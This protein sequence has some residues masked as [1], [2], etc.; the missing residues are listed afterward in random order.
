MLSILLKP[1]VW[2]IL[3]PI[4]IFSFVFMITLGYFLQKRAN[5]DRLLVE[6]RKDNLAKQ[7][8]LYNIG[9]ATKAYLPTLQSVSDLFSR[10]GL[11]TIETCFRGKVDGEPVAIML[12]RYSKNA[13]SSGTTGPSPSMHYYT[14]GYF[15][16]AKLKSYPNH[17]HTF[18]EGMTVKRQGEH[19]VCYKEGAHFYGNISAFYQECLTVFRQLQ[20]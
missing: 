11:Q 15:R 13:F 17:N 18:P 12:F 10:G 3:I 19:L 16:S 7:L 5:R 20:A 9:E 14:V 8:G 4:I 6:D 1:N 2:P